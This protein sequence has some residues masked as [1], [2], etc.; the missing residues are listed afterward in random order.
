MTDSPSQKAFPDA[1]ETDERAAALERIF[2]QQ[3]QVLSQQLQVLQRLRGAV[4]QPSPPV[5]VTIPVPEI[6][7]RPAVEVSAVPAEPVVPPALPEEVPVTEAQ[8]ALW[9]ESRMDEDACRA[10]NE[11]MV[12]RLRGHFHRRAMEAAL[13]AVVDRHAALR[14]TLAADG[15]AWRIAP[16]LAAPIDWTDLSHLDS[17]RLQ[18]AFAGWLDAQAGGRLDL[19]HG[20]LFRCGVARLGEQEHCLALTVHHIVVDGHSAGVILRELGHVYEVE[21]A[22]APRRLPPPVPF[23]EQVRRTA[24]REKAL[25]PASEAYWLAKFADPV[26]PL[27][28]PADHPRPRVVGY[29]GARRATVLPPAALEALR[30]LGSS[31]GAT[32][33]VTLLAA[34]GAMLHRLDG[35]SEVVVGVPSSDPSATGPIV[36]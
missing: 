21:T 6:P 1:G 7:A 23:A 17:S 31:Q 36:G 35:H 32:L 11:P 8:R 34:W 20:P 5:R 15:S 16:A 13:Q 18:A 4:Q 12:L 33:F 30:A 22:G 19:E 28:L 9:I 29:A 10:Y 26:P 2:A 24:A 14:S 27:D 25:D 3:L